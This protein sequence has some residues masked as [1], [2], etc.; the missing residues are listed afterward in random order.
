MYTLR[1]GSITLNV[2]VELLKPS[3]GMSRVQGKSQR[4]FLV[5]DNVDHDSLFGLL[6]Q[7]SIQSEFLIL[8][9]GTSQVLEQKNDQ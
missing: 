2:G 1:N 5:N 6:F 7:K 9:W 8:L 3:L 4:N